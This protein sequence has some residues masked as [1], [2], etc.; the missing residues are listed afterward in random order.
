MEIADKTGWTPLTASVKGGRADVL[1]LLLEK[2][3]DMEKTLPKNVTPLYLTCET[4]NLK[5]RHSTWPFPTT[6]PDPSWLPC[7]IFEKRR[8]LR[9]STRC[10]AKWGTPSVLRDAPQQGQ[11][12]S[13]S[14]RSE[15]QQLARLSQSWTPSRRI[16][17]IYLT[18]G[19][20]NCPGLECPKPGYQRRRPGWFWWL[21]VARL[22][23]RC[24]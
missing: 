11:L 12:Q 20:Q 3:A 18:Y 13:T 2:G 21:Y 4:G 7:S 15:E 24:L 23:A 14:T 16:I 1:K 22:I 8:L 10:E 9:E 5:P 6:T 19:L 17:L